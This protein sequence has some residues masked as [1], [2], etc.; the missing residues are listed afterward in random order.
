MAKRFQKNRDANLQQ[1]NLVEFLLI[2]H[3]EMQESGTIFSAWK[4]GISS[5]RIFN[6]KFFGFHTN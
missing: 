2:F 4:W 6:E 1:I 3:F 5:D